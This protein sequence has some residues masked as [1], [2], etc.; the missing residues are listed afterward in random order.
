MI[1]EDR[2]V[3]DVCP[4]LVHLLFLDGEG[5]VH[6]HEHTAARSEHSHARARPAIDV[7]TLREVWHVFAGGGG[8]GSVVHPDEDHDDRGHHTPPRGVHVK[9]V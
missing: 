3:G 8:V 4:R 7:H 2:V 9:H 5:K 6:C 1:R